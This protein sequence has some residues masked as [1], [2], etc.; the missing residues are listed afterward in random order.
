LI[1]AH[2]QSKK[3]GTVISLIISEIILLAAALAAKT[4]NC[5][6]AVAQSDEKLFCVTDQ[7]KS[8]CKM[9]KEKI[10]NFIKTNW[11]PSIIIAV[12]SLI[13]ILAV[14]MPVEVFLLFI[15]I[16]MCLFAGIFLVC[17]AVRETSMYG[18]DVDVT[19]P[20]F[21]GILLLLVAVYAIKGVI[22]VL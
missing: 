20:I 14:F 21:V 11:E 5:V 13:L 22:V 15:A 17:F 12:V 7:K 19:I 10:E 2:I 4:E 1:Y 8:W 3:R 6:L 18:F 16:S 9:D